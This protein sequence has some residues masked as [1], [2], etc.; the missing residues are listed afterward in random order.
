MITQGQP[1]P[2]FTAKNE[3][4]ESISSSSF[5]DAWTILYFYPKDETSG[6]TAQ[7]CSIRDNTEA[8]SKRTVTIYGISPD[9]EKSHLK[10]KTNHQLPFT[11]LVDSEHQIAELF[12][13]WVEKSMYGKKYMGIERSTFIIDAK[14]TI[15]AAYINVKPENHGDFLIQE[16][17]KL[18][19]ATF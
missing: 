9:S 3:V 7:A 15:A 12:G 13:V 17:D 16:L 14:G 2:E 1:V 6:C 5:H 4:G 10:F 19:S 18:Q 11:L 8:F